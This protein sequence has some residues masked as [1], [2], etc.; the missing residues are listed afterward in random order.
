L[1]NLTSMFCCRSSDGLIFEVNHDICVADGCKTL[2]R[3]A[4]M[5]LCRVV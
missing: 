2:Y 1:L 3:V 4:N 5:H